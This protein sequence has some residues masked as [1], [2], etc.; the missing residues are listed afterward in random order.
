[1]A[2]YLAMIALSP[3]MSE[4]RIARWKKLENESFANGDILCEVETDKASMDYEAPRSGVLLKILAQAGATVHVGDP[5]AIIGKA[6]EDPSALLTAAAEKSVPASGKATASAPSTA[7]RPAG[8]AIASESQVR[9]APAVM[10]TQTSTSAA[11]PALPPRL[12][13]S[14]P[15]ART[16]A[17]QLG[18]DLRAVHGSGPGGRV[19][20]R[21]VRAYAA[22][23]A[24]SGE[25]D[26]SSSAAREKGT[27][28]DASVHASVEVETAAGQPKTREQVTIE[29]PG[30]KRKVIARRL[31]ESFFSA[32]HYYLRKRVRVDELV[33]LRTLANK[34]R[35]PGLS[36]NAFLIRLVAE[37]LTRHPEINV[38]WREDGLE[39]RKAIDIALAV[40]LPDGLVTP[41]IRDCDRKTVARIDAELAALIQ[42]A[43]DGKLV[44]EDYEGAGFT[45]SNL[46]S[47]GIDEFTAIINPPGS[48]I[49]AVGAIVKEPIVG[50]NDSIVI[51]QTMRLTLG[52]DHRSIDGAVGAAFLADLARLMEHPAIALV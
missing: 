4:G 26:R 16:V 51:A 42:K 21:D 49:L 7:A 5:I 48:A 38:F 35:E 18:I 43:R 39:H 30:M 9:A 44:P 27:P 1:M 11:G 20:E 2:E 17:H 25:T 8:E 29:Q 28:S 10:D 12:P 52:C 14:T 15:L 32:P 23:Q 40:A 34:G 45:I 47:A 50:D 36:F 31:S 6:G 24:G 13:P 46:G 41:V 22:M 37:A 3:T 19:T 33:A